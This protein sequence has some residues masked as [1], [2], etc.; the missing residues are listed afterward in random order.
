MAVFGGTAHDGVDTDE[1]VVI[2]GATFQL[3]SP[4]WVIE[5]LA[6]E[7]SLPTP[8]F[9][10]ETPQTL[11]EVAP[12]AI[13]RHPV[14]VGEYAAF[15]EATGY[16][17]VAERRGWSLVYGE[18]YWHPSPGAC[19]R[20]PAGQEVDHT[21]SDDHPVVHVAVEDADAYATWAGKRLPTEEQWEL[22]ARGP[23]YRLW[24]W[25]DDWLRE[26]ANTTEL[27]LGHTTRDVA[28]WR[29]WW[30]AHQQ[31]RGPIPL[32]TPV[33]SLSPHGDSPYGVADM[34][35][36]VY[37]WTASPSRLYGPSADCDDSLLAVIGRYRVIR[38]GSWMNLRFQTRTSERLHG[39][40]T[41]WAC[42]AIGFRC[43]RDL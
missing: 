20:R 37:E 27:W 4:E 35:G 18:D 34:A 26:R 29:A 31:G 8:W 1:S 36:N 19:W 12:F 3:G 10:D 23:A 25:G 15:V 14:T 7:Q 38:G 21:P 6:E 41:G 42:F 32:T 13:D 22:A 40:P 2:N 28:E 9:R 30:R 24:P 5:W 17:T 11:V 43:V 33:G 16:R 39:D